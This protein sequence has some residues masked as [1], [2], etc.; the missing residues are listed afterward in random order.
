MTGARQFSGAVLLLLAL[1][2][3]QYA[4]ASGSEIPLASDLAE[5]AQSSRQQGVPTIVFV[6]RDACPYCRILRDSVLEPMFAADKFERRANLVE[7]SLDRV[8]P[9]KDFDNEM[10]SAQ[11]FAD[12]YKA[13]ITPT[14][15]FLDTRG[16]EI[17]KRRTGISNLELYDHYLQTS[18]DEALAVTRLQID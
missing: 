18:I 2:A 17:G 6:T 3:S 10:I 12:R 14:L 5:I 15:L 4:F 13:G 16:H 8:E 7:V 9:L 11:A 1:S